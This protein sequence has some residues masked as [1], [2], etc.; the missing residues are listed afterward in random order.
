MRGNTQL[1]SKTL[2]LLLLFQNSLDEVHGAI[3][4]LH[5]IIRYTSIVMLLCYGLFIVLRIY[6]S[7]YPVIVTNEQYSLCMLS[8]KARLLVLTIHTSCSQRTNKYVEI[9][10]LDH[11]WQYL[12]SICL[13][14]SIS[15]SGITDVPSHIV[16][17]KKEGP[18]N[19]I[20][21]KWRPFECYL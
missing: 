10:F 15:M 17:L 14:K 8:R 6:I 2:K 11:I 20:Y 5:H 18:L 4:M 3:L 9:R 16:S 19:V 1:Q 21:K 12:F 7:T 13:R